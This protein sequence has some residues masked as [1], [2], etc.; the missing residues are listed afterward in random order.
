VLPGILL[1]G[2]A[3]RRMGTD[4]ATIAWRGETLASRA[5]RVLGQVCDPVVE[6]GPGFTT[7]R[8]IREVPP[9]S[10][11]LAA[12]LAGADA[13]DATSVLLLACDM[14]FV[15]VPL[16]ELLVHWP[17]DESVAAVSDGR[18]QYGCARY[19]RT[20]LGAARNARRAG[21]TSF[22]A[23]GDEHIELLPESVWQPIAGRPDALVDI[24]TPEEWTRTLES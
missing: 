2:G 16:L 10:G 6:A 22:R 20:W 5:A 1:T 17:G 23:V 12:L 9:G 3:S 7:L 11:P 24:D 8:T 19:G 13:L 4:K 14:P 21:T 15:E 18:T